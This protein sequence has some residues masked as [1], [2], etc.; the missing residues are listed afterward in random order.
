M[1][2][3]KTRS[4]LKSNPL[5]LPGQSIGEERDRLLEDVVGYWLALAGMMVFMAG[6]E[7]YRLA[8]DLK[9]S[10]VIF[11]VAALLVCSFAAW[12]I[13]RVMPTMRALR[14]AREGEQAVGQFLERLR[15][16]GYHIF[17]DLIGE[18]FN[19][20]HVLVGPAG[21]FTVETKTWS[22]PVRG[23]TE[24][25][26]DGER[27][28]VAGREPDRDPVVQ[29]KAQANWIRRLLNETAGRSP[30]VKPVIVFPG[31]YVANSKGSFSELWVL[32]PK[33]LPTFLANEP[34]RMSESDVQLFSY[35]LSRHIRAEEA[36]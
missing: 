5:R 12:R 7:W 17:H 23:Q 30:F 28:R 3:T 32:E 26:F 35:H 14:Q 4:P 29:A 33:A 18:N 20:D 10:P 25:Q 9:P 8:V 27:I 16:D 22:K 15:A 21:V 34:A 19:I 1:K 13:W 2:E 24:I 36:S 11:T 31:W 6:F